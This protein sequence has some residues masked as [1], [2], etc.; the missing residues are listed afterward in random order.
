MRAL[1]GLFADGVV[2]AISGRA[3]YEGRFTLTAARLLAL[4]YRLRRLAHAFGASRYG[5]V[6]PRRETFAAYIQRYLFTLPPALD[7]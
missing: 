5:A 7:S 2:G 4:G 6:T 1:R 3:L